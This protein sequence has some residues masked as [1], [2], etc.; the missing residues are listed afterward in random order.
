M[1]NIDNV[2]EILNTNEDIT[3]QLHEEHLDISKKHVPL[4]QVKT[5]KEVITEE[6]TIK[7]PVSRIELVIEK[8]DLTPSSSNETIEV[9]RIPISEERIDINK[10]MI[11]L[12]EVSI[13]THK[14]EEIEHINELLKKEKLDIKVTGSAKVEN[15]AT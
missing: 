15:K 11:Q 7:I 9:M 2:N 3:I 12:E 14:F 8:E 1:F 5:H 13:N 6:R 4:S 10:Q